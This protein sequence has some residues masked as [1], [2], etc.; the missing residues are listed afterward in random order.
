MEVVTVTSE[1]RPPSVRSTTPS[2]DGGDGGTVS[3][4]GDLLGDDID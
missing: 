2:V 3:V 1:I 4:F